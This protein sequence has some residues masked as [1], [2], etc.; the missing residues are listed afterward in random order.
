MK[1]AA[2]NHL[3][4][5]RLQGFCEFEIFCLRRPGQVAPPA[6]NH[7]K[8]RCL[9]RVANDVSCSLNAARGRNRS[10]HFDGT[11]AGGRGKGWFVSPGLSLEEEPRSL[12]TAPTE[13]TGTL[14]YSR[15]VRLSKKFARSS[16]DGPLNPSFFSHLSSLAVKARFQSSRS[17]A[18]RARARA[19]Q[20]W[21]VG[22]S[23]LLVSI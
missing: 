9:R 16:D 10:L 20:T 12:T 17:S 18:V 5:A 11:L 19:L 3:S 6:F 13:G 22:G 7:L 1:L 23:V 4:S 14:P 2:A 15:L 21:R 8:S